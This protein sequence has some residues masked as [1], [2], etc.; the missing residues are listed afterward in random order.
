MLLKEKMVHLLA[1][2]LLLAGIVVGLP[3]QDAKQPKDKEVWVG[4]IEEVTNKNGDFRRAIFSGGHL[5]LTVMSIPPGESIGLEMHNDLDQFVRVES[6]KGKLLVGPSKDQ[7]KEKQQ[8]EDDWAFIIPAGT[9]H[10]VV[11]T[12]SE[13]LKLYS[14]Y[15]PP[16]HPPGTVHKT[17]DEAKE[18]GH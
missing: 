18:H 10:N 7:V 12:G 15:G 2:S 17:A 9:W 6:G 16:T 14:L 11:N 13:P 1:G 8:L 5:Q 3:A 4:D